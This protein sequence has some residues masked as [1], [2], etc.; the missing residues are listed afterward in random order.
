VQPAGR[1]Q[2]AGAS[3]QQSPALPDIETLEDDLQHCAFRTGAGALHLV[4]AAKLNGI[5]KLARM[6]LH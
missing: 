4:S 1:S 6:P 5:E 3:W 2:R